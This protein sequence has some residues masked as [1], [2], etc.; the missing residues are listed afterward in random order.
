[1]HPGVEPIKEADN[2]DSLQNGNIM[3]FMKPKV[4]TWNKEGLLEHIVEFVVT[5]DK[6]CIIIGLVSQLLLTNL[7]GLPTCVTS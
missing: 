4:T 2:E 6:V 1:M 7:L 3:S 5:K